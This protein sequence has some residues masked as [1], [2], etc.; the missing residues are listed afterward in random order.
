MKLSNADY[1]RQLRLEAKAKGLCVQCRCR[2]QIPG[3]TCCQHCS[4]RGKQCKVRLAK[5]GRCCCGRERKRGCMRCVVCLGT[6]SV[7]GAR[8]WDQRIDS[9]LCGRCGRQPRRTGRTCCTPCLADMADRNREPNRQR[10]H[11]L[12]EK[13]LCT[14]CGKRKGHKGKVLCRTCRIHQTGYERKYGERKRAERE[15]EGVQATEAL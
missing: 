6:Q 10:Y 5:E 14:V 4:D 9:G 3:R 7:R 2:E 15:G 8:R 12:R 1:L 13:G 11:T